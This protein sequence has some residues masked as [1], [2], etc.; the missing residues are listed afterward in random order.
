MTAT[1]SR[2]CQVFPSSLICDFH[3][4]LLQQNTGAGQDGTELTSAG[5]NGDYSCPLGGAD[6]Q[7]ASVLYGATNSSAYI[8]TTGSAGAP[9]HGL[10][11]ADATKAIMAGSDTGAGVILVASVSN[12]HPSKTITI[13]N[14]STEPLDWTAS[15]QWRS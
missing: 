2:A 9:S 7:T 14:G 4:T 13:T 6:F 8:A 11:I 15:D 12:P 3:S 1:S 10:A 5:L